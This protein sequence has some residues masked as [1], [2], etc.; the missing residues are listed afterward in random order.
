MNVL[1]LSGNF[2]LE[3]ED[4]PSTTDFAEYDAA[5][6]IVSQWQWTEVTEARNPKFQ[7]ELQYKKNFDED[8][9]D[10]DLTLV[11][12]ALERVKLNIDEYVYENESID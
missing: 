3:I 4:Q 2:A 10:L 7:Y 12:K 5:N 6:A 9:D 11:S 8:D 1:T